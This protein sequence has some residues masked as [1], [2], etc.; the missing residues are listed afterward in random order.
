MHQN[1]L[2]RLLLLGSTAFLMVATFGLSAQAQHLQEPDAQI[3]VPADQVAFAPFPAPGV[4]SVALYGG[5]GTGMPTAMTSLL[6]PAAYEVLPHTHTH[7]YWAMVVKG[8]MQH[9]QLSEP[10]RGPD[11]LPGSYWFQ[12]GGVPHAE[13]CLGPE[14]CQVFVVFDAPADFT[15]VQ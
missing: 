2:S 6:D 14:V 9:W 11:L 10:D 3:R 7:G 4:R 8:R 1:V 13:D 5:V 15:P 12:P